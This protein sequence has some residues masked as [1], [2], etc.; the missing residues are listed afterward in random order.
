MP[1]ISAAD[2]AT[3]ELTS[4]NTI[5]GGKNPY[6]KTTE[7]G[8]SV[9]PMGLRISLIELYDR[10]QKPL[11]VVENGMGA[12][13]ILTNDKKIHDD[14][15]IEYFKQHLKEMKV[16]TDAGVEILGYTSWAP[17]DSISAATS[18]ISKRYRFIYVDADD[19]GNGTYNCYRMDAFYWYQNVIATNGESL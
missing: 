9:D 17:I 12:I 2:N 19:N 1:L 15:R 10:Y 7:W 6:L 5:I 8:W 16:A 4:G 11:F 13:D 3:L 14:Y 18:Q